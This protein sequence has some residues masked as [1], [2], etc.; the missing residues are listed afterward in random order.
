MALLGYSA[1]TMAAAIELP[2]DG[3]AV[4]WNNA[5]L[6]NANVENNGAN[7][8]STHDGTTITFT[9]NNTKAQGYIM[10]FYTGA[11]DAA[12]LDV[13]IEANGVSYLDE[14]VTVSATGNWSC[15]EK[16]QLII[17]NLPEGESK[18]T[19]FV[20]AA[21]GNYAGN[22]GNLTFETFGD[23]DVCPGTLSLAKGLYE[24]TIRTENDND[25]VGWVVNGS[26]ATYT[27][28]NTE[29]GAYN[30]ELPLWL[31]CDKGS[32]EIEVTNEA[33]AVEGKAKYEW[34]AKNSDYTD[35]T[36]P[37]KGFMT[38]GVKKIKFTFANSG[39]W[40]CNYKAPK[41]VKYADKVALIT[42]VTIDGTTVT[43]GTD[44]DW[45]ANIPKANGDNVTLK[46]ASFSANITATAKD[47]SGN[48]VSVKDNGDG[49]FTLAAPA[50]NTT[51]VVTFKITAQEG[52]GIDQDTWTVALFRI[53]EITVTAITID[54]QDVAVP[55]ALNTGSFTATISDRVATV[56]PVAEVTLIDGSKIAGKSAL[57]GTT[58]TYTFDAK[59]GSDSRTFTIVLEGVKIY[60]PGANDQTADIRWDASLWD[61][62]T[63]AWSDGTFT[64][65][66]T[67][68]D[69]WGGTQFKLNAT[70]NTWE[71]PSDYQVKQVKLVNFY[72]NYSPANGEGRV[73]SIESAGANVILPT[74]STYKQGQSTEYTMI[75]NIENHV[76]GA[77]IKITLEGGGQPVAWFEFVY[78][79]VA[80][81]STPT[82]KAQNVTSTENKNHCVVTLTFDRIM[83][84]TEATIGD[85]KIVAEG[86]STNLIFPVWDLEYNKD[87]T[88]T[89]AAGAAKDAHGNGN[90]EAIN[91][92][93][94]V[95]AKAKVEKLAYDYVVATADEFKAALAAVNS[96]NNKAE[97]AQKVI[98][99][100]NG[101]YD[102]GGT[103]QTLT[104]Y[105]VSLIGESRDGVV[106]RGV[107]DG[108]T[109]PVLNIKNGIGCYLQ[110]I[111]V[112][113]ETNFGKEEKGGVGVAIT[114]GNKTS[115]KNVRMQSNQDTHVTGTRAYYEN[116]IIHGT[117]DFI[118]GGGDQYFY[119]TQL[120]LEDR[121]GNCI[122]APNTSKGTKWGYVF[123]SCTISAAEGATKVVD[124][125]YNLGRPWQNEPRCTY[126]N[127]TMNVLA[128]DAGWTKMSDLPTHFYEYNSLKADGSK[129]D[130]SKRQNSPSSTN[131]YNPVLTDA[132]AAK[133][134]M[135]NVLG[136]TDSWLPTEETAEVAAP[137][138]KIE[139][140]TLSWTDIEDARCYAIYCDGKYVANIT[141]SK[142]SLTDSGKYVV[143]A[144]NAK[145]GLGKASAE[146]EYQS[147]GI[148]SIEAT[149]STIDAPVYNLQGQRV[150]E[151]KKGNLYIKNGV[152]F[153][154]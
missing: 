19:F 12:T 101:D 9:L 86:G 44:T 131:T 34:E 46:V 127:T 121:G 59:I 7:V 78:E 92:N 111:T 103:E 144:A 55:E 22:W 72:S 77:P 73:V 106:L 54:G 1:N 125:G 139:G 98:F 71:F 146:I 48:D 147:T 68:V 141:D 105:N 138:A 52:A 142:Y 21:T 50:F 32:M 58:A 124:G 82:L 129:V 41:L 24:E 151:M 30:L 10:T 110:D 11:K 83:N 104:A 3:K 150:H 75:A 85:K 37:L 143:Y 115:F 84:D 29:A 126:L 43:E 94:K 107:R 13:N 63:G 95:G 16:H 14:S 76:A 90:A 88:F 133:F 135:H 20:S 140:N 45:Y 100:K 118:C 18:L 28:V 96:S 87:Y 114:G 99:I 130:L 51:T 36:I 53:G 80:V 136:G 60:T 23:Y 67:S 65:K 56:L 128:S 27:F 5:T 49:T 123:E 2:G 152:K 149:D 39:S 109:N 42:G 17:A 47:A 93:I 112:R 137:E 25:N 35:T 119:N 102:F 64:L 148:N 57:N 31:L 134:T 97:A 117:V 108:I 154:K 66:T 61:E 26:K 122:T 116:C 79:R 6:E 4:D 70:E 8:G 38:K 113:N 62:A 69:G 91:V 132:E 145:G 15:T 74:K 89:V 40:V 153:V 120:V 81:S 33:G